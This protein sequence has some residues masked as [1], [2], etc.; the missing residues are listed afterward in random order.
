MRNL[1]RYFLLSLSLCWGLQFS[2]QA[3]AQELPVEVSYQLVKAARIRNFEVRNPLIVDKFDP[4]IYSPKSVHFSKDG[5]KFYINS[6]EG[7]A[8]VVYAWPSLKKLKTISHQFRERDAALFNGETTVFDYPYFQEREDLNVFYGK[9]VESALS[10][11]GRYLWVSYYR[12]DYDESAQSPSAL[13]IIDTETDK[14]IRVM[15]TGP[16]P[17]YVA[18]SPDGRYAAV[19]HW[20]DN[21]I[22]LIDTH[23]GNPA[24]YHYVAH[25]TVERQISQE[26]LEGKD[27][28][29]AC[30][31]CLR[32][33][34]FD[35]SSRY[36]LVARMGGGGIAGFDIE[37]QRYLGSI[38]NIAYTPRHLV[39]KHS[40]QELIVSSNTSGVVSKAPLQKIIETLERAQ[41][42]RVDRGVRWLER[43]IGKGARTLDLSPDEKFVFVAMR[44]DESVS[45][46]DSVTLRELTKISVDPYPVGLAV[47][48]TDAA[49]ITTSQGQ[50]GHGG[51]SVNVI[52]YSAEPPA[53]PLQ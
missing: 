14:I 9:P 24:D 36:L 30:G 13:A 35:D 5:R 53:M 10:N 34:V 12:R 52:L 20:G 11:D 26:G 47:S 27:R 4:D 8:T 6:L 48:P 17:K 43:K 33:A 51:N 42:K 28:D 40:T 19:V 39:I 32:G 7:G 1:Q 46:L 45:M 50:N 25:L 49:V 3:G 21:T 16:I 44:D 38:M 22:G 31:F 23:S 18:M 29:A 37:N 41:G 2:I 15:P